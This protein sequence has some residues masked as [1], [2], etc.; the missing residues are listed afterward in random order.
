MPGSLRG[1]IESFAAPRKFVG[2]EGHDVGFYGGFW[3]A[4]RLSVGPRAST[5][6]RALLG[7]GRG[8]Q[9]PKKEATIAA[10]SSARSIDTLTE[11]FATSAGFP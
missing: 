2:R 6:L 8:G 4:G 11:N 1:S 3:N 9:Q 7:A 10:N 5:A